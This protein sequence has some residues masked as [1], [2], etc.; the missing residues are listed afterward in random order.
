MRLLRSLRLRLFLVVWAACALHFATNITREHYP[1]FALAAHG[2]LRCDDWVAGRPDPSEPDGVRQ[3]PLHP[4][5]FRHRDGHWYANNNVGAALVA[6]PALFLFEPLLGRLDE[7][8]RR[9]AASGRARAPFESAYPLRLRF[10]E[11][12]R[13]RGL[14]LR[15][16]ASAAITSVLV[17][18]P[19]AGLLALLVHGA[20]TARG[21]EPGRAGALTLLFAFATPLL[22]RSAVLN[23]NQMQAVA[24]F[25]SFTL[26]RPG[27]GAPASAP[28]RLLGAG[29][30]A[31]ATVL[32]DWSGAVLLAGLAL[33]LL[34]D[35]RAA[36]GPRGAVRAALPFAA[37][38]AVPLA[39]LA[40]TQWWQFGNALLPA[41]RWMPDAHFSV[42]GWHGFD[43][44]RVDLL[45]SNLFDPSFGL[46]AFAPLLL[47]AFVSRPGG[48]ERPAGPAEA[49][50]LA[51]RERRFVLA[52]FA[53][54]LL[55]SAANQ[56]T[57]LQWNTGFRGLAPLVP[58]LFLAS[59]DLLARAGRRTLV[60]VAAP[61]ALHSWVLAMAR[62]TP[63]VEPVAFADSTI[64]RSWTAI[65]ESGPALPWLT[66]W[67]QT[68]PGGGPA[69]AAAAAPLLIGATAALLA[70]A[71][72]SGARAAAGA[73]A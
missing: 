34:A 11:E 50:L 46:F 25:A 19:L 26:L 54:F 36:A 4:D 9:E 1:A 3:E 37:G 49:P 55:F 8:G 65:L 30:L 38:A 64:A 68:Q 60:L 32:L 41:Q 44:P 21:V 58:F 28:R 45:A 33:L 2:N 22:F 29:A 66:V 71:W 15:L 20:L 39:L 6:A 73:G 5:L 42:R 69:W 48:R 59:G 12:V 35:A 56:F 53:A 70:L 24:A 31:G 62:A 67:R 61:L 18:A 23:H 27:R 7:I 63:P 10:M 52:L 47:L 72:R 43:W 51:G 17:M 40:L 57:R 16:G 13:R 14:H